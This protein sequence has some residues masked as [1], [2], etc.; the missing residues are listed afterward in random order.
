MTFFAIGYM[1]IWL[2]LLGYTAFVHGQQ[3]K[4]EREIVLLQELVEQ[5][6]D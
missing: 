6:L 5:K 3:R 2:L 4:L 1:L